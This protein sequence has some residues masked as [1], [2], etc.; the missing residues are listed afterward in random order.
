MKPRFIITTADSMLSLLRDFVGADRIPLNAKPTAVM[1][2]RNN[3]NQ[4][5]IEFVSPNLESEED[6]LVDFRLLK[7]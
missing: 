5:A 6:I 3:K 1:V 7:N 4:I 2:Q